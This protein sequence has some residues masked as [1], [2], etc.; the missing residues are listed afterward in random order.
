MGR[1]CQDKEESNEP[2]NNTNRHEERVF[3]VIWCGARGY[4]FSSLLTTLPFYAAPRGAEYLLYAALIMNDFN[5]A[6]TV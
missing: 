6:S 1:D 5:R 2:L 3:S 4:C